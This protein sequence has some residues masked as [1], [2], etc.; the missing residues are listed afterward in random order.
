M[1]S[2]SPPQLVFRSA[3]LR[4]GPSAF[5]DG[6]VAG[7]WPPTV[8]RSHPILYGS[9]GG[10]MGR[11]DIPTVYAKSPPARGLPGYYRYAGGVGDILVNPV[12]GTWLTPTHLERAAPA[13]PHFFWGNVGLLRSRDYGQTW[14][15][16]GVMIEPSIPYS[17]PLPCVCEIGGGSTA[18]VGEYLYSYFRETGPDH[19]GRLGMAY[20]RAYDVFAAAAVNELAD[21]RKWSGGPVPSPADPPATDGGLAEQVPGL[22]PEADWTSAKWV[23]DRGYV[24]HATCPFAEKTIYAYTA[25][26][27]LD[28]R[29]LGNGTP[30]TANE[31]PV[32]GQPARCYYPSWV[33]L[34]PDPRFAVVDNNGFDR[35]G[36]LW[37]YYLVT[38]LDGNG[39]FRWDVAEYRRRRVVLD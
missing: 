1:P 6:H 16:L 27:G 38:A 30:L 9:A 14:D 11:L 26:D 32:A 28:F 29:P 25:P 20:A 31:P 19:R 17:D 21:W 10:V 35:G 39:A 13:S 3:N 15:Y 18:W 24:L 12:D 37:L 36:W 33:G 34:N 2:A 22:Q 8:G 4:G 5:P 23:A 7:I